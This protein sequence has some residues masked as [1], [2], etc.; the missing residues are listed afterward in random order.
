MLRTVAARYCPGECESR[1][2]L[3]AQ[4]GI[5]RLRSLVLP[6]GDKELLIAGE[7]LLLRA[8]ACR[9]RRSIAVIGGGDAGDVGNVFRQRLLAVDGRSGNGL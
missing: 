3:L 8:L 2:H 7:A 4:R 6:K 5:A 1:H 9:Q